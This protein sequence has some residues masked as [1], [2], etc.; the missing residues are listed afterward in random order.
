MNLS[1]RLDTSAYRL[2][3]L[4]LCLGHLNVSNHYILCVLFLLGSV[5]LILMQ[6]E[7]TGK[8]GS[9]EAQNNP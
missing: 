5:E 8:K 3:S 2:V 9:Y 7:V 4:L 6:G 1:Y